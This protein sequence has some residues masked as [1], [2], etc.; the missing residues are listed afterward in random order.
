MYRIPLIALG[1]LLLAAAGPSAAEEA[2]P[3][4]GPGDTVLGD[5]KAPV[6]VIE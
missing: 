3:P 1:A 2:P 6:T 5:A 4:V